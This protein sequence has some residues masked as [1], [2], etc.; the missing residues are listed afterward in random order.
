M[1]DLYRGLCRFMGG[2]YFDLDLDL[3]KENGE[4]DQATVETLA[5]HVSLSWA[6]KREIGLYDAFLT[7]EF[8]PLKR[9]VILVTD[10]MSTLQTMRKTTDGVGRDTYVQGFRRAFDAAADALAKLLMLVHTV[11]F[12]HKSHWPSQRHYT[13][14]QWPPDV[15]AARGMDHQNIRQL[16]LPRSIDVFDKL[17]W[18]D[19]RWSEDGKLLLSIDVTIVDVS[20][21]ARRWEFGAYDEAYQRYLRWVCMRTE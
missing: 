11:R 5:L 12:V 10:R 15:L 20:E 13:D 1:V 2:T 16:R 17:R 14:K 21:V 6:R 7:T 4:L 18:T 9:E 3:L 19:D 8:K